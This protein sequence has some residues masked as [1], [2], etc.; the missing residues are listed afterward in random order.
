MFLL[1]WYLFSLGLAT[2]IRSHTDYEV[3]LRVDKAVKACNYGLFL[4]DAE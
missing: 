4:R 1:E 3:S 2:F